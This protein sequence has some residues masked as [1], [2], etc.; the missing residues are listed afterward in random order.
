[1]E[2]IFL[3]IED[4]IDIKKIVK[5]VF[6]IFMIIQPLLDVYMCLFD[7]KIQIAGTSLATVLRF[8]IV[9]LM[10]IMVMIKC[11]KNKSTKLFITYIAAVLIYMIFH[12][13]NAI[14]FTVP[15]AQA[16]Y[17]LLGEILYIARMLIPVTMIYIIYCIKPNYRDIKKIVVGSSLI[18]SLVIII[19]NLS[20]TSYMA[21]SLENRVISNNMKSWFT[22]ERNNYYWVTLTSRGFFQSANQLSGVTIILIPILTYI[23]LKE[24]RIRYWIV[25]LFHLIAMLNLTTRVG[26]VGSIATLIAS[27]F[28][29]MFE[30]IIHKEKLLK[31]FKEKNIYCIVAVILIYGVL[32]LKSPFMMRV[33]NGEVANEIAISNENNIVTKPGEQNTEQNITGYDEKNIYIIEHLPESGIHDFFS[34]QAYPIEQDVDFWY[35]LLTKVPISQRLGNRKIKNILMERIF[36]RDNRISNYIVGISF[37]RASSF[38]WPERDFETQLYSLGIIGEIL[39]VSPYLVILAMGIWNYFKKFRDNLYLSRVIYIIS[40]GLGIIAAYVSGHILNE[41]FPFLFL[42]MVSGIILNMCMGMDIEQIENKGK[43]KK[44]FDRIF[45]NGKEKFYEELEKN[46]IDE[47]KNFIITA[48]PETIMT[49]EKDEILKEAFLNPETT[50]IPDGVGITKG[51]KILEYDIK[52]TVLGVNVA[53]KLLELADKYEKSIFLFGAKSEVLDK[54]KNVIKEKY[55]KAKIVGAI[56]GY[57]EDKQKVFNEM[58][59]IKPDIVLVALGIPAQEKLIYNNL[60]DFDKGIFVGVGGSFDVISGSKKRA[61]KIFIKTHLEWLYRITTEPKRIKRFIKSNVKYVFEIIQE[62]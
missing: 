23:A 53:I 25:V 32:V 61:P 49:S 14:K 28:I 7:K 10:G 22:S 52:E 1:M 46:I 50:V 21:Y 47:K 38:V 36:E 11:R 3:K 24:K 16:S 48:N 12:H 35:D 33:E 55:P 34:Y 26:V 39:F 5:K 37:T 42:S 44:Y 2:K 13:I 27:I 31:I 62:R 17:S 9:F 56:D 40:L 45:K 60:K 58:R 54:L 18:I 41:M 57:V 30:K 15:L 8:S 29:Y 43:F 51:A 4:K 6:I 19:S 20:N 59:E